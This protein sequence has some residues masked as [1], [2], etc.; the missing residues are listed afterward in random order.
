MQTGLY[1]HRNGAMGFFPIKPEVRTLNQQLHDAGY[2]I[3]MFGKGRHHQPAE[4]FCVDVAN[5][6]ISRHPS[7]LADATRKF[8][9]M[10]REQGRP[11]FHNVNCYD[12]HRPFIGIKGPDDLAEGEPPSR[13]IKPEEITASARLPRGP[14][15]NPPGIGGL[16]HQRPAPRR[17]PR[18]G[19]QGAQGRR[20][21][22]QHA[23]HVLRRRPRDVVSLREIE[24]LREQLARRADHPLA[25]RDQARRRGPRP[26]RLDARFRAH[27]AGCRR[28]AAA[29]RHRRPLVP[30]R[31]E[32]RNDGRLGPRLHLLQRR[33]RQPLAAD[34]LRPHQGPL[35]HLERVERRQAAVPH[36]EHG[37]PDLE[38][39][40][41]RRRDQS[42]PSRPAPTSIS[43]AS[44]R[45]STT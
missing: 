32:G 9:K 38:S 42:R 26:P 22:R 40:A 30:A 11:F 19:A 4:K 6:T 13:W 43:T 14:A 17:R 2:L 35:L 41:R 36:R 33:L 25:R 20:L 37:R 10:A 21:R 16:L 5:D 1:P 12:P 29:S 7:Q 45:S 28:P 23:G 18:R 27:A 31:G 24:R 39:H 3:S 34:A 8:L 44:P 15:G